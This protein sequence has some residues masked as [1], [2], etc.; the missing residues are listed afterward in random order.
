MSGFYS[1][2]NWLQIRK[3]QLARQ[4][5]CESCSDIEPATEVDHIV[6][7]TQGGAKRDPANLQSLCRSCHSEKTNA[8]RAGRTWI[9]RKHQGCDIDG[10]PRQPWT[11][12]GVG[13]Q[14]LRSR[15]NGAAP[16]PKP[17]LIFP[18]LLD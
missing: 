13:V 15:S 10:A 17:E 1:S 16:E 5:L 9:P 7:I 14:E 11:T 3:R 18:K 2:G 6:P 12:R 8:E 4:P